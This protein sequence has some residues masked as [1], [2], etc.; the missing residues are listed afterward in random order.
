M[1]ANDP[2]EG[3]FE[4]DITNAGASEEPRRYLVTVRRVEVVDAEDMRPEDLLD[5]LS[6]PG[7]RYAQE[8]ESG[9]VVRVGPVLATEETESMD[10]TDVLALLDDADQDIRE[11]TANRKGTRDSIEAVRQEVDRLVQRKR[12]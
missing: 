2:V 5:L 10:V 3:Q 4:V 8:P 12:D 6:Q 9:G 11:A 7:I 1:S